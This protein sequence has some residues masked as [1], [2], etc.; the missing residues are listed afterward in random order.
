MGNGSYYKLIETRHH[1]W[2]AL[3]F[4]AVGD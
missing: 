2:A 4:R 1:C 3:P